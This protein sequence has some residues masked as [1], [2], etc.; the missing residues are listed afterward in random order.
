MFMNR[1]RKSH[2][3]ALVLVVGT[4]I[5]LSLFD[6]LCHVERYSGWVSLFYNLVPSVI[7]ATLSLLPRRRWGMV[8]MAAS[9]L[10]ILDVWMI[11]NY[12]YYRANGLFVTWQ[13][14][15]L[16]G[17]LKGY[18]SALQT[19]WSWALL[20]FPL[21]SILIVGLIAWLY[22]TR[23]RKQMLFLSL[24][25][26]LLVGC[27]GLVRY[28]TKQHPAP[29]SASWWSVTAIPESEGS[30]VWATEFDKIVY[31]K[32]HSIADYFVFFCHDAIARPTEVQMTEADYNMVNKL[33][34]SQTTPN[35][36]SGHLIYILVESLEGWLIDYNDAEGTPVCPNLAQWIKRRPTLSCPN[37]RCQ[38]LYGESGDGQMICMTGMLPIDDGVACN[39]YGANTF[40]NFAH[41][42]SRSAIINPTSY[43]WNKDVTTYSY[44]FKQLIQPINGTPSWDDRMVF[45][46]ALDFLSQAEEPAC[47]VLLTNDTHMPF[48]AHRSPVSLPDSITDIHRDYIES[49]RHFDQLLGDFLQRIESLPNIQ[50]ATIVITGDHYAMADGFPGCAPYRCPAVISSPTITEDI[51]PEEMYQMDIFT[52]LLHAINQDNYYWHGFGLDFLSE[53][54]ERIISEGEAMA[55]SNKLIRTN[56]FATLKE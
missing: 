47:V 51:R 19:C 23:S 56:Y 46:K 25:S 33:I 38:K 30:G 18:T 44:G 49:F 48:K 24:L 37:V 35:V 32:H 16:A 45:D 26:L 4:L 2:V 21:V 8:L 7:V 13:V 14:A 53:T 1:I 17:Q 52:T 15:Q 41:F 43:L 55:L 40:P 9:V 22:E 42:Y 31:L 27:T 6:Y 39:L 3:Q 12:M 11:C 34:S 20:L 28:Q 50:N 10:T 54:K 36:P 29:L 5:Q